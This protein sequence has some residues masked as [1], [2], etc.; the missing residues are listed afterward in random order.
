MAT[1]KLTAEKILS[2]YNILSAAKYSKLDDRDKI[3]LWKITRTLKPVAEQLD[4]D[5]KSAAEKF[6]EELADFDERLAMAQDFSRIMDNVRGVKPDDLPMS[7][8]EFMETTRQIRQYNRN[9]AEATQAYANE[10]KELEIDTI[11]EEAF[12][13]LINSNDWTF[14]HISAVGE[15]ITG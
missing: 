3:R 5:Q 1:I 12:L 9:V 13:K 2:A 14:G 8:Q 10:E 7:P 11:S 6:K 15:V 4:Q